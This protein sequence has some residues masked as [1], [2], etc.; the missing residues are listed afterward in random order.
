MEYPKNLAYKISTLQ[1]FSKTTV[2]LTPDRTDVRAGETFRCKMPANTIIDL[3]TLS[4]FFT[5][6]CTN[7]AGNSVHF[8]RLT[9]SLIRTLA[10]YINGTLIERID[11]YSTLYNKLYDLDG[12]GIDQLAK[13]HLENADP[14][15]S[16][17]NNETLTNATPVYNTLAATASDLN[18][19]LAITNWLGFISS[20][21]TPCIDTNDF[22][23]MEIEITLENERVLFAGANVVAP[24]DSYQTVATARPP[25]IGT[26]SY[27][28]KNLHFNVSKIVFN[29]P[30]YYNM[31]ASKLLSSGLTI[32]YQTFVASRGASIDKVATSVNCTVNSTSLDQIICC[33]QPE[34]PAIQPLLLVGSNNGADGS[35]FASVLSGYS[36]DVL[37]PIAIA[38][39]AGAPGVAVDSRVGE[40]ARITGTLAG[41]A[42]SDNS[43][44]DL[45]NQSYYFQSDASGLTHSSIEINNTPLH[46]Q[47]LED[48]EIFNE[49]LIALGNL[50]IDMA[51]GIHPGCR[52][53]GD[54]KKYYFAFCTSLEN[55]S[56]DDTFYKSGLDGKASALNVVW[57][58]NFT[59]GA[60][61][62]RVVP[63]IF[64]K[65]TRILQI[66]EGHSVIVIV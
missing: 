36:R 47:P 55:L 23:I 7:S 21:S 53:L 37:A 35:T 25:V 29:D 41:S 33:F 20:S 28:L 44:G 48:D 58:V 38:A 50:N 15:V 45:Y 2:R 54:F 63:F 11:N 8:P 4:L 5:G 60:V 17:T 49:S 52:S 39:G 14:S 66:N 12:G 46:P 1:N 43:Y 32:G 42:V 51:S 26:V 22:G 10:V 56:K 65:T 57:R 3:R 24:A 13:R 9:S 40:I 30:M 18:R 61:G 31:K 27:E 34:N 6:S 62:G 16:Y 59:A 64:A 19:K